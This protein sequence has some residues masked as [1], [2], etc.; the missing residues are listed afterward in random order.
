MGYS[1]KGNLDIGNKLIK[2]TIQISNFVI[3]KGKSTV[4]INH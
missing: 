3:Q 4:K 2:K 1:L